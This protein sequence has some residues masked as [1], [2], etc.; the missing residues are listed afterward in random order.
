MRFGALRHHDAMVRMNRFGAK[1]ADIY[2]KSRSTNVQ[3]EF[4]PIVGVTQYE[5]LY[6]RTEGGFHGSTII[7]IML[8]T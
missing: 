4:L 5:E 3:V 7:N 1:R 6:S 2:A 8:N